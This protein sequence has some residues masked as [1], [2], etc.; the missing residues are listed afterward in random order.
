MCL[1]SADT[2]AKHTDNVND[3]YKA[4]RKLEGSRSVGLTGR[5]A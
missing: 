3:T 4:E 1:K 5:L 2:H